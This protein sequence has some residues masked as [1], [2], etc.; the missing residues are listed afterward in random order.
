MLFMAKAAQRSSKRRAALSRVFNF[1]E[2]LNQA[3]HL[4][5]QNACDTEAKPN[6][7]DE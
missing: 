6:A 3:A 7:D 5:Q 2:Q 1:I 4:L